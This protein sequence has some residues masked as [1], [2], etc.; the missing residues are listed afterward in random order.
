MATTTYG[1]TNARITLSSAT[2]GSGD[3]ITPD[4][5]IT[6][7]LAKEVD[8][9][10][11]FDSKVTNTATHKSRV[12]PDVKFKQGFSVSNATLVGAADVNG[13]TEWITSAYIAKTPIYAIVKLPPAS[14]STYVWKSWYNASNTKVY[15]LKGVLGKLKLKVTQG[16]L[17][18]ISCDFKEAWG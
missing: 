13:T 14:G 4:T 12:T 9:N 8:L 5:I 16:R 3:S 15:Y 6:Y 18:K 1:S 11:D 10:I 17:I 2:S 7:I